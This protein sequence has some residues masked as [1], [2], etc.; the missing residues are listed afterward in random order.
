MSIL[1]ERFHQRHRTMVFP[2][3][4]PPLPEHFRGLPAISGHCSPT[5]EACLQACPTSALARMPEGNVRLDLGACTFCGDCAGI[6]PEHAIS[7]GSDWRM[8]SRSREGLEI[9]QDHALELAQ[10]LESRARA[11]FGHSLRIRE[12]S[13][14]GCG[15]CEADVNVLSTIGWDLSRFGIQMVASPRHADAL[16]V[17]GP[18]PRSMALALAKTW[19]AMPTPKFVIAVGSC[20]VSGGLFADSPEHCGGVAERLPV[21]LFI[22]GCP[23]HPATIL[24]GILRFLGHS[25]AEPSL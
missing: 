13:A 5:C 9:S 7:F 23:P 17:T 1:S 12:V 18:V 24:D 2:D 11:L 10:S 16:L 20:A 25:I 3:A 19:D 14:G 6:C 21:N 22:P 4:P 15:A 8:A